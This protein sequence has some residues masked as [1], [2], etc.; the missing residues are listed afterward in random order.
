M[1]SEAEDLYDVYMEQMESGRRK[2]DRE[3]QELA[4]LRT[5]LSEFL[6]SNIGQQAYREYIDSIGGLAV[7]EIPTARKKKQGGKV[8]V[9]NRDLRKE[10]EGID[11]NIKIIPHNEILES[12]EGFDYGHDI[13]EIDDTQDMK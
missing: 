12:D 7:A 3:K 2:L 10:L 11:E 5:G 9:P 8:K 6:S 13:D 1:I 4:E